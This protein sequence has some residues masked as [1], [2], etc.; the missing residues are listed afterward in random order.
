MVLLAS[1][2]KL[3]NLR[4]FIFAG[5][6]TRKP[7]KVWEKELSFGRSIRERKDARIYCEG[8]WVVGTE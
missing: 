6:L 5:S 4:T 7:G 8:G 2:L 1:T 3:S